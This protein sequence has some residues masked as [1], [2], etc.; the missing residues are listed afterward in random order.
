[1]TK[2]VRE[3]IEPRVA[4]DNTGVFRAFVASVFAASLGVACTSI[5][6]PVKELR[7]GAQVVFRG[8]ISEY[9]D[10]AE[11]YKIAVFQVSRVWKG[12]VGNI[13]EISTFPGYS[14]VPAP[15][16]QPHSERSEAIC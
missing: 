9:R 12:H 8:T 4:A 14:V 13:V 2:T 7:K 16:T 15:V 10:S 6:L 5:A 1:M 3:L 11:G